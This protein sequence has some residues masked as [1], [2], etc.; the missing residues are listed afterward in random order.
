VAKRVRGSRS[1]HRPGGQGPGRTGKTSDDP[2][3]ASPP[4]SGYGAAD[5]PITDAS[6]EEVEVDQIAAAAVAQTSPPAVPAAPAPSSRR[7]GRRAKQRPDDLAA[8]VA[9]ENVWIR[10][11][12][13]RIGVISVILLVALAL[14]WV[15]FGLLD[16]L[17]L[18]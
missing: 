13:R 4:A 17:G 14:A 7:T 5:D 16:V 11:D 2:A 15:V 9:A 1:A 10:E 6:Y 8:R 3:V 18:Y 12:L